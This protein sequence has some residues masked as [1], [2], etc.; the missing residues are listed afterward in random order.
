MR[1]RASILA[2][3]LCG[4]AAGTTVDTTASQ[5][6]SPDFV[7]ESF[8]PRPPWPPQ[9]PPPPPE[10]PIECGTWCVWVESVGACIC[11]GPLE[12]GFTADDEVRTIDSVVCEGPQ[13]STR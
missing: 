11:N 5:P 1:V 13:S 6:E 2:S 9:P 10:P 3:V 4:A 12:T 8:W 7:S